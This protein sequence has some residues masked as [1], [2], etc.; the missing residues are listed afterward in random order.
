MTPYELK[1]LVAQTGSNFFDR[2]SMKFF[3]DT[4]AN[5]GCRSAVIDTYDGPVAVWELTRR[6][7]VK[8][9][10]AT[11]AYFDKETFNRVFKKD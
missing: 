10:L 1:Y 9:G 7:P 8:H 5:Y 3:G 6:R 2:A 11:S 4:M